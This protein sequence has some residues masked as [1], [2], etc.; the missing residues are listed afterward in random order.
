MAAN[1]LFIGVG[2][3]GSHVVLNKFRML[4]AATQNRL[5]C[6]VRYLLID[7]DGDARNPASLAEQTHIRKLTLGKDGAGTAINNGF[8]LAQ[9]G[10]AHIQKSITSCMSELLSAIDT[11]FSVTLPPSENQTVVVVGGQGGCSG[12][13]TDLVVTAAHLASGAIGLSRLDVVHVNPGPEMAWRD[14]ERSVDPDRRQR[15]MANYAEVVGWRFQTMNT[16][17]TI[18]VQVPGRGRIKLPASSR[19]SSYVEF[20][21][22]S[23]TT[24]LQTTAELTEMMAASL[25]HRFFTAVGLR[26]AS[27]ECDDVVS[28]R[29]GQQHPLQSGV[30]I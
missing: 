26:R 29:T 3:T 6:N 15:I 16:Q 4:Q 30:Q 27:R 19:V 23:E 24:K 2:T 7:A 21:W 14:V 10:F 17:R 13:S 22:A 8:K 5:P 9:K 18:T 20:D 25:L 11:R 1:T 12:G 28:G